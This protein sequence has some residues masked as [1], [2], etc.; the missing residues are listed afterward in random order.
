MRSFGIRRTALWAALSW[1]V[2]TA[3]AVVIVACTVEDARGAYGYDP[4]DSFQ[5]PVVGWWIG[6]TAGLVL[7]VAVIQSF[8]STRRTRWVRLGPGVALV[9]GVVVALGATFPVDFRLV[10]DTEPVTGE[11]VRSTWTGLAALV[12]GYPLVVLVLAGLVLGGPSSR[13]SRDRGR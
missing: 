10:G 6:L 13:G 7:P 4:G 2:F 5:V 9:A 11:Q 8:V 12:A 3:S 1:V